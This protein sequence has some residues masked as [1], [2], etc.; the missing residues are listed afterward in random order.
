MIDLY[1]LL[2]NG[3]IYGIA[4][5]NLKSKTIQMFTAIFGKRTLSFRSLSSLH[6]PAVNYY[7]YDLSCEMK[8]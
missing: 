4:V 8:V 2:F 6:P 3:S 7:I 1:I 5:Q